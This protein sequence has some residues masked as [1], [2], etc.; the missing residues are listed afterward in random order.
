MNDE[1]Q[2]SGHSNYKGKNETFL[3]FWY[4]EMFSILAGY[5]YPVSKIDIEFAQI[6]SKNFDL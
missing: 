4:A 6:M 3:H 5:I 1:N 2:T